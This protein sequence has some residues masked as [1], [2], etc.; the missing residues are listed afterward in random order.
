MNFSGLALKGM[1]SQVSMHFIFN[2][3]KLYYDQGD[4]VQG[5]E[6]AKKI[7]NSSTRRKRSTHRGAMLP[8]LPT[9]CNGIILLFQRY[10]RL[11]QEEK[12]SG[13]CRTRF[14]NSRPKRVEA[15]PRWRRLALANQTRTSS[16]M[17]AVLTGLHFGSDQAE[18]VVPP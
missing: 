13:E 17:P 9:L 18:T 12:V 14:L 4:S 5:T 11:A 2:N 3:T 10:R 16:R 15:R 7:S 1:V 6:K 8:L